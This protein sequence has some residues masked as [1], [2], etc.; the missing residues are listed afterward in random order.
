MP[1]AIQCPNSLVAFFPASI[2]RSCGTS[3]VL[4]GL[5]HPVHRDKLSAVQF[6]WNGAVRLT[7]KSSDDCESDVSNGIQYG[8]VP[9]RVVAMEPKSH[10]IYLRDCPVEVSDSA[11]S[12]FFSSYG[13]IHSIT[14]S[15]YQGMPGLRDG[16]RIVKMTLTKDIPGSVHVAYRCQP[17][18][19]A[20]W[21]KLGHFSKACHLNGICRRC[22][23]SG[24]V[25]REFRNAWGRP[26]ALPASEAV[27]SASDAAAPAAIP[28]AFADT[29]PD[30]DPADADFSPDAEFE[31]ED[32]SE[33]EAEFLSGDEQVVVTAPNP[34]RALQRLRKRKRKCRR[35]GPDDMDVNEEYAEIRFFRT[36]R[37][38][39]GDELTWEEIWANKFR[40]WGPRE[41]TSQ[42]LSQSTPVPMSPVSSSLSSS[43]ESVIATVVV[44]P[45]SQ[46]VS[47]P[48]FS[49]TS[50][51]SVSPPE[52]SPPV[53]SPSESPP[54]P[55]VP[56]EASPPVKCPPSEQSPPP[57]ASKWR[58]YCEVVQGYMD[59]GSLS[60]DVCRDKVTF[61]LNRFVEDHHR[62]YISF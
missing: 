46:E 54:E 61:E 50:S 40:P 45:T 29:P 15:E 32:L 58:G 31:S 4:A 5:L 27:P 22:F 25:A 56:L 42:V 35:A 7:Y 44:S 39:W 9:L 8:D 33:M 53:Q 43:D 18:S 24:H 47:Q 10:L 12:G 49:Q 2:Y 26:A 62:G 41:S 23:R 11:V 38:V 52:Q 55:M 30:D 51:E 48:L 17:P 34:S 20:I 28:S 6:L 59:F 36:F 19:C 60:C 1:D 21:K 14:H 3:T 57:G 13:E 16:T 37:E